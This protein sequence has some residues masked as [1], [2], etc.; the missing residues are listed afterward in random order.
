M[1]YIQIYII[2]F[3]LVGLP[4]LFECGET[5]ELRSFSRDTCGH[6][7]TGTGHFHA[8]HVIVTYKNNLLCLHSGCHFD[9]CPSFPELRQRYAWSWIVLF[10]VIHFWNDFLPIRTHYSIYRSARPNHWQHKL[11]EPC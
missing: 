5:W 4:L 11:R 10:S 3:F 7:E 6:L 2:F 8:K 9:T 1:V